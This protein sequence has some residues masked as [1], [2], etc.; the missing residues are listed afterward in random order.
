LLGNDRIVLLQLL[1]ETDRGIEV[2][3]RS[4]ECEIDRD[5]A[6][7]ANRGGSRIEIADHALVF[8]LQ[9]ILPASRDRLA[10]K[11]ILVHKQAERAGMD[12]G[13]VTVR[14]LQTGRDLV[15]VDWLVGFERVLRL[16]LH[17]EGDPEIADVADRIVLLGQNLRQRLARV[18]VVMRDIIVEIGLD[19]LEHRGPIRP[20]RRAVVAD[21]VGRTSRLQRRQQG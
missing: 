13:P 9:Q 3:G 7:I 17:A 2:F 1:E 18:F 21:D 11:R 20:L 8:G 4:P 5:R 19:R 16:C 10:A 12:R 14:I 6:D 15:P